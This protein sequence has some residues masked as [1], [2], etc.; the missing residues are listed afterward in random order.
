M[1]MSHDPIG[2][3]VYALGVGFFATRLGENEGQP[4]LG[5]VTSRATK[6]R[7]RAASVACASDGVAPAQRTRQG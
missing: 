4:R 1:W 2:G 6:P 5:L 7:S 3:T